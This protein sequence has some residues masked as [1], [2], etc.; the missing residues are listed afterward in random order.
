MTDKG[1]GIIKCALRYAGL[2]IGMLVAF[3]VLSTLSYCIPQQAVHR[4]ALESRLI[5]NS[6]GKYPRFLTHFIQKDNFTDNL[7]LEIAD[8]AP[9][10]PATQNAF[11]GA[12]LNN[13]YYDEGSLIDLRNPEGRGSELSQYARYWHGYLLPLRLQLTYTDI[14]GIR[15]TN[16]VLMAILMVVAVSLLWR[17]TS[18]GAACMFA[19][20]VSAVG[21]P[22]VPGCMQFSTCFYIMLAAVI[23]VMIFP[24]LTR[25]NSVFYMT[26]FVTGGITSYMDF[27]TTPIITLGFP[28]A[29]TCLLR[30][31]GR[32]IAFALKAS[33]AWGAGYGSLWASKWVMASLATGVNV[34]TDASD[35]IRQRTSDTAGMSDLFL[36]VAPYICALAALALFT[37]LLCVLFR[38]DNTAPR[39]YS[40]LVLI[41]FYPVAWYLVLRNH[42]LWHYWFTWR[43]LSL[44]LF[45][46][47]LY[48]LRVI[49]FNRFKLHPCKQKE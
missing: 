18:A 21:F 37:A 44:P 31:G 2:F 28:L 24:K 7:M 30:P 40:Y 9:A 29:V 23:A 43:A 3:T 42:S 16:Y 32:N 19:L 26:M 46:W 10:G 45:C 1:N 4:N 33:V 20:A 34:L 27:L 49:D 47:G 17:R 13:F 36:A 14:R 12:M 38:K 39:R 15:L 5:L 11:R 48:A 8:Y 25:S 6:E 35:S 41:G 22:S